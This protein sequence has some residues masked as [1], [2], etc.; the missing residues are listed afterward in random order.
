MTGAVCHTSFDSV[1]ETERFPLW[2]KM[3]HYLSLAARKKKTTTTKM[4]KKKRKKEDDDDFH[5]NTQ[6]TTVTF[7]D[8]YYYWGRG[9]CLY[10]CVCSVC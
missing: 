8:W 7:Y 3:I 4:K 6:A 2:N 5:F 10:V 1:A 9:V